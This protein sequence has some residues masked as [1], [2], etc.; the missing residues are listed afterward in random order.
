MHASGR[1]VLTV[2]A[3]STG[4][5]LALVDERERTTRIADLLQVAVPPAA[6]GHRVVFGGARFVAPVLIDDAVLA[7]LSAHSAVAPLH[8]APAVALIRSAREAFPGVPHVA[9]FDTAFHAGLPEEASVYAV[10]RRW[11]DEWDV[12]R[13]G[14]HGLSV[15]WAAERAEAMLQ[16]PGNLRAVVCHLGGGASATAV[17][18]GRSV[19]T[20]MGFSPLEGLVMATRSGTLDPDIPLHL[21]LNGGMTPEEVRRMLNEDSG[22]AGLAG[23]PDMREVEARAAAGDGSAR[24]ALD[25]H[26]HRLAA[27]VAAMAASLGGLDALVFTGGIG[28]GSARVRAEAARR[29]AFLGVGVDPDRNVSARGDADVSPAGA[30]VRTLVVHAR[31]EVVIARAARRAAGGAA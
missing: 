9:A 18:G 5:K 27:T 28:E 10:P 8:N 12:R 6:V 13:H 17:A 14:F 16:R 21:I 30:A 3:G 11:R 23:T 31:E 7:E 22:M 29:L 1:D 15:E 20:S 4:V 26:D 19:D 24:R 25:V 2:N